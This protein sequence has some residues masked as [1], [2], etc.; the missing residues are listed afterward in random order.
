MCGENGCVSLS[1]RSLR[2]RA[3]EHKCK[4][5]FTTIHK[6]AK[7]VLVPPRARYSI[8]VSVSVLKWR[9]LGHSK[10]SRTRDYVSCTVDTDDVIVLSVVH[11]AVLPDMLSSTFRCGRKYDVGK[12]PTFL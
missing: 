10:C 9:K 8:A 2:T 11:A 12:V 7:G 1:A 3:R 4:P 5:K 6:V